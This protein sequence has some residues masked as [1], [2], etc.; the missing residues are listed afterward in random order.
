MRTLDGHDGP[1]DKIVVNDATVSIV[2]ITYMF[3]GSLFP[4]Q[5]DIITCSGNILRVWTINGELYL[6]KAVCSS[7]DPILSCVVFE[8]S[9]NLPQIRNANTK[10]LHI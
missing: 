4:L 6:S 8:V 2:F 3:F 1:V 5:G 7:A 10:T 9:E